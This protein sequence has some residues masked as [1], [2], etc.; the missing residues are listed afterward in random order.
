MFQY[1]SDITA[2]CLQ[3]AI[4]AGQLAKAG[5]SQNIPRQ[6][7]D[8]GTTE[9]GSHAVSE[10]THPSTPSTSSVSEHKKVAS[11]IFQEEAGGTNQTVSKDSKADTSNSEETRPFHL[12]TSLSKKT[13]L[14]HIF[15][16]VY[17]NCIG[18]AIG[19]LTE[20]MTKEKASRVS[21]TM[22]N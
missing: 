6:P 8:T 14:K 18:D 16:V 12:E 22:V 17:G 7:G 11:K 13:L 5:L 2:L 1:I 20:F 19:L 10:S 3:P 21:G 4:E 9:P 15:G